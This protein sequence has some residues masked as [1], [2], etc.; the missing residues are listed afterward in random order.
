MEVKMSEEELQ[1]LYE[2]LEKITDENEKS[3]LKHAIS[4]IEN[5]NHIY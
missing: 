1:K 4:I 5:Y 2:L 3:A